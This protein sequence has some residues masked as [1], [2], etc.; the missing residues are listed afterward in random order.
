MKN[1]VRMTTLLKVIYAVNSVSIKKPIIFFKQP[2][3][4]H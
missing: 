2:D 4:M 3:K 1:V